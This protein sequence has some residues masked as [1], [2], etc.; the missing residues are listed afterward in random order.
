MLVNARSPLLVQVGSE[1]FNILCIVGGSILWSPLL[2]MQLKKVSF[3][4]DCFFYAASIILLA[5]ALRDSEVRQTAADA[6]RAWMPQ[7]HDARRVL[8]TMAC[9]I[10]NEPGLRNAALVGVFTVLAGVMCTLY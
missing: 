3:I 8:R 6:G 5:W 4:R 7:K 2:P 9:T 10:W 1:I